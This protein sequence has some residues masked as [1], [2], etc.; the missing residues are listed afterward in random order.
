MR[1]WNFARAIARFVA[2]GGR[3][4]TADEYRQR[5]ETCRPCEHRQGGKCLRC[6]CWVNVKARL[7]TEQ[8][9][10][11]KWPRQAETGT[12]GMAD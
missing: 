3:T 5:L 1:T 9:P 4:V 2:A 7:P 10:T 6:R 11:G 8:C 12:Q